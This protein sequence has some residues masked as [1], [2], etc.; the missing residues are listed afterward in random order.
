MS[1]PANR[2]KKVKALVIECLAHVE[3][4]ITRTLGFHYGVHEYMHTRWYRQAAYATEVEE[5][6]IKEAANFVL[7]HTHTYNVEFITAVLRQIA[8]SFLQ[9]AIKNPVYNMAKILDMPE[10]TEQEIA[11]KKAKRKAIYDA[12]EEDMF[13]KLVQESPY[14]QK[15]KQ[16]Q[17]KKKQ[18]RQQKEKIGAKAYNAA[19][20]KIAKKKAH[21]LSKEVNGIFREVASYKIKRCK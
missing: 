20:N 8:H 7:T 6:A 21:E 1:K 12:A 17:Q 2:G 5:T 13:A 14:L 11:E 3:T 19:Q 15:L 10:T 4:L 9:Y 18:E 16:N